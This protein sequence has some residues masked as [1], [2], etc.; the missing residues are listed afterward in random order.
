MQKAREAPFPVGAASPAAAA[1]VPLDARRDWGLCAPLK[2]WPGKGR[3]RSAG[4]GKRRL[5]SA[6][7]SVL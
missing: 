3:D 4:T 6:V 5:A 2:R 1:G 7:V